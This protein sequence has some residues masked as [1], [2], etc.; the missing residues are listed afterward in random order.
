M[1]HGEMYAQEFGWDMTF[2]AEVARIVAD[3]A[4]KHD[5]DRERGWIAEVDGRRVGCVACVRAD[6]STAQL[7]ILLVDPST[8]GQGVGTRLVAECVGFA[9]QVG[10]RRI[11]LLTNDLLVAARR[12]YLAAGFQLV[13]EEPHHSF[14]A[15]FVGQT[16]E[17]TLR[18]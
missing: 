4:A 12:V 18:A 6:E 5:P 14:G 9:R 17:L 11:T 8:R 7:R 1:A 3:F 2:E 13:G 15:N 16:Y 10:Y